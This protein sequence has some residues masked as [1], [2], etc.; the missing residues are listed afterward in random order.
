MNGLFEAG[1]KAAEKV[2]DRSLEEDLTMTA[3]DYQDM[4]LLL[5]NLKSTMEKS[6][7][8]KQVRKREDYQRVVYLSAKIGQKVTQLLNVT[9]SSKKGMVIDRV[10]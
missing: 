5:L 6:H 1:S 8:R 9:A 7:G 2:L 10:V 3:N 4:F